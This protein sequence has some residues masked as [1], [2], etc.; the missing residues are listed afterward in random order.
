MAD[1]REDTDQVYERWERD[2]IPRAKA[3]GADVSAL[4]ARAFDSKLP[5]SAR[6]DEVVEEAVEYVRAQRAAFPHQIV[7]FIYSSRFDPEVAKELLDPAVTKAS[8]PVNVTEE[9]LF[10]HKANNL[11][12]V[13]KTVALWADHATGHYVTALMAAADAPGLPL[14]WEAPT[15]DA[16]TGVTRDM[17]WWATF[18]C[19]CELARAIVAYGGV[20]PALFTELSHVLQ[21][22]HL[23]K[24][25]VWLDVN[26]NLFFPDRIDEK[27]PL[28][29]LPAVLQKIAS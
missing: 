29:E 25:L 18:R 14:V 6:Q 10:A 15:P 13:F 22:P 16:S 28:V 23:E 5:E 3:V 27:W 21:T 12:D 11:K 7:L 4:F 26:Q 1:D 2:Y 19:L 9:E 20:T 17:M 24:R 8:L